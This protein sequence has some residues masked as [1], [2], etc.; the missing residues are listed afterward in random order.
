MTSGFGT[1]DNQRSVTVRRYRPSDASQLNE[2]VEAHHKKDPLYGPSE[3]ETGDE[4]LAHGIGECL[5]RFVAEH[6]SCVV[7]HIAVGSI[8]E[9]IPQYELFKTALPSHLRSKQLAEVRRG[10]V[11]P[12]WRTT[13][14]G[15]ALSK[16][17]FRWTVEQGYQP[18]AASLDHRK[19][20]AAM[21]THYRWKQIA[22]LTVPTIGVVLLWIPPELD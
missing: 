19:E 22:E 13:G 20:S 8:P 11:H 3:L 1:K 12:D 15:G 21:L 10:I 16:K 5:V 17:A 9:D 4:W 7:G 14:V 6:E 18:V 2:L